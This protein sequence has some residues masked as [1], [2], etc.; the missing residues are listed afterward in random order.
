M[1]KEDKIQF[2]L[3]GIKELAF[4]YNDPINTLGN[5]DLNK[6][7]I[8]GKFN[9]NYRW[10]IDQNL[11]AVVFDFAYLVGDQKSNK[12]ECLNLSIMTEFLVEKLKQIFTVRSNS[13]FDIDERFETT[14]VSITISTARGVLFEK[15][16]GT[17][18]SSFVM[19][20]INPTEVI[21]S[22]KLKDAK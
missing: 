1:A 6:D 8:E 17:L 20:I 18:F 7:T 14:L 11:F 21:L 22:K 13:D 19:P 12:T 3:I 4:R 5:I 9:I 16:K 2:R 15:S 10:N